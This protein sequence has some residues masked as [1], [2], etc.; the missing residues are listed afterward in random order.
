MAHLHSVYDTDPHFKIDPATR[1]IENQSKVKTKIMQYDHNSERFT[2]EIPK[3]IDGHDMTQCDEVRIHFINIGSSNNKTSDVYIVDDVQVSPESEDIVIFSWLVS[4]NATKY[5]GTLN[6]LVQFM[7][8]QEDGTVDYSWNTDVYKNFTIS[9]GISNEE[10]VFTEYSDVLIRWK[11]ELINAGSSSSVS[12]EDIENAVNDYFVN[13]PIESVGSSEEIYELIDTVIT[14]ESTPLMMTWSQEPD[15]TTYK[16]RKIL[17]R[18]EAPAAEENISVE[19]VFKWASL[20]YCNAVTTSATD[21]VFIVDTIVLGDART[22]LAKCAAF[23]SN[24]AASTWLTRGFGAPGNADIGGGGVPYDGIDQISLR[25]SSQPPVGTVIKIY[26]V[27]PSIGGI[28]EAD[29]D[30]IVEAVLESLP[31]YDGTAV[32]E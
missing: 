13:N 7:C 22:L 12:P 21:A 5:A 8:T 14:D 4:Q 23:S 28:T 24:T 25:W 10:V 32:V 17:I 26:G 3:L 6:F 16:F 9:A 29:K 27:R 11:N 31:L 19:S 30:E 15:G 2:F 1:A 18:T 20:G